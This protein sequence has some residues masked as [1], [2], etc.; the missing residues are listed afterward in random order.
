MEG[1]RELSDVLNWTE[2]CFETCPSSSKSVTKI[3]IPTFEKSSD[4]VGV[5]ILVRDFDELGQ[6][7]K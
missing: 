1:R 6:V 3:L 4:K 2:I 5:S 7:S